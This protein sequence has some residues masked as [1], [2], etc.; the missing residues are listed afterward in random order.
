MINNAQ[1]RRPLKKT[2]LG[3]ILFAGALLAVAVIAE[4]QQPARIPRIG[5]IFGPSRSGSKDQVDGFRQGLRDRGYIEDQNIVLDY[6]YGEGKE[7]LLRDLAGDLV[8]LKVDVIVTSSTVAA[9]TAKQ[10]T[11][12]IPIVLAGTGDPVATGLVASLARPRGNVTGLSAASPE[13]STKQLDLLREIV[14]KVSRVAVLY[15]PR[16]PVN[17]RA[18]KE[19]EVIATAFRIQLIRLEVRGPEDYELALTAAARK[20]ADALLVRRAPLN[21]TYQTQIVSL[22]KRGK[23]PAIYPIRQYVEVGGLMSYGID[24]SYLNRRAAHYVDKILKAAKP[25]DLPVQPT[26]FEFVINLKTAKE[27][28]VTIPPDVLIVGGPSHQMTVCSEQQKQRR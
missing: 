11:R 5:L 28:G 18:W 10:L 26:K 23:L 2:A 15:D 3:S 9:I 14:P 21:Q 13:L 8:H 1:T 16:G 7:D 22:A 24:S 25:V 20:R 19:I 17:V 27:I 6:R 12:T 4:A